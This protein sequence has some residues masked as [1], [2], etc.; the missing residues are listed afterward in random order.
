M[1]D[2]KPPVPDLQGAQSYVEKRNSPLNQDSDTLKQSQTS[3]DNGNDKITKEIY[4]FFEQE[5]IKVFIQV[6]FKLESS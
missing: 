6:T 5:K 1:E 3:A 2:I 4:S